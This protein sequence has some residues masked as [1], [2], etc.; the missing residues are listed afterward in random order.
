VKCIL[1]CWLGYGKWVVVGFE[2]TGRLSSGEWFER[3]RVLL[4]RKGV[5]QTWIMHLRCDYEV[6][7]V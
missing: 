1:G 7:V 5:F 4:A 2:R 6:N 3:R